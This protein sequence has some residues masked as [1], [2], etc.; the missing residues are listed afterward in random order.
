MNKI[1][2]GSP[3]LPCW[4]L[5][6]PEMCFPAPRTDRFSMRQTSRLPSLSLR[7]CQQINRSSQHS[8]S[9]IEPIFSITSLNLCFPWRSLSLCLCPSNARFISTKI[10]FPFSPC[11]CLAGLY[12]F[13]PSESVPFQ[14]MIIFMLLLTFPL[15]AVIF[16]VWC[17]TRYWEGGS[18][19]WS[20]AGHWG[21]E[22]SFWL[23]HL[24]C[25]KLL[26]TLLTPPPRQE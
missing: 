19:G 11:D 22:I 6:L 16:C 4:T 13:K 21:S 2:E 23:P 5:P 26:K 10:G 9:Q 3:S 24:L 8:N 17:S 15:C 20:T 7:D 14:S 12:R 25:D 1:Y 18:S